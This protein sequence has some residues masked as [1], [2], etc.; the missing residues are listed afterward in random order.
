MALLFP[1]TNNTI[2]MNEGVEMTPA[3]ILII[4]NY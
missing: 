1:L 4:Y 3:S 2:N